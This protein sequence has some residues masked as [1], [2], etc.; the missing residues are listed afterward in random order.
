[1]ENYYKILDTAL[2]IIAPGRRFTI[3][4]IIEEAVADL[5]IKRYGSNWEQE[6]ELFWNCFDTLRR[7][8]IKEA[9]VGDIPY[10]YSMYYMLLNIPKIQMVLIQLMRRKH[11]NRTL[12]VLDIG[13][14]VGTATIALVDLISLLD[15]LCGLYNQDSFFDKITI[16]SIE[17]SADNITVFNENTSCFNDR[18]QG[19]SNTGKFEIITPQQADITSFS[20]EGNYDLVILSNVLNEIPYNSR[21]KLISELEGHLSVNGDMIIIEPASQ[22]PATE[23]N[24]LKKDIVNTTGLKCIAPCGVCENCNEC[25]IY[26]ASDLCKCYLVDYIDKLYEKRE[27]TKFSKYHNNRLKWGYIILS[28]NSSP[29]LS[30]DLSEV[31]S[32]SENIVE[33]NIIGISGNGYWVCDGRMNKALLVGTGDELGHYYFGDFI[34]LEKIRLEKNDSYKIHFQSDSSAYIHYANLSKEKLVFQRV[35][36]ENL[37]YL[38][39]RLW[40]FDEFREGQVEIIQKV[41]QGDDILGL[42][43]TGA[44][45]S[46]CYQLPTMLGNGVS[47]IVSPLKSL[48]KDQIANLRSIGFEFVDFIDSSKSAAEKTITLKRFNSGVIKLL[49]VTPERLQ[50]LEFQNELKRLLKK[51][52]IDYFIIDEAHCASEWGHDFRPS[53]LKLRDIAKHISSASIV[54]VTATASPRVKEDILN[55]FKIEE[56][57]VISSHSLDRPEIS[58]QVVLL[59]INEDKD[60]YL[61]EVLQKDL[62]AVF[63]ED[64]I[65]NIHSGGAGIVFTI[66]AL[67]KGRNTKTYGTEHVLQVVKNSQI[68]AKLYHSRLKDPERD[69]IQDSFKNDRFPLLVSTKGFGMGIDKPNIRYIIHMCYTNSLEA[70]YQE[71]GRAGRDG[72]HAHSIVIAR[73][74]HRQC[75][76]N[77]SNGYEPP[78][79][80]AWVCKYTEENKCDYGMQAWF[81]SDQYPA[82][83]KIRASM[84]KFYRDLLRIHNGK[85]VFEFHAMGEDNSKKYQV[86]LFYFQMKGVIVNYVTERYMNKGKDMIFLVKVN[87]NEFSTM[88][89]EP[90]IEEIV[91]RILGFK[92]QKYNMLESMWEYV[93]NKTKCRRQMLMDYLNDDVSYGDGGCKFCDIDGISKEKSIAVRSSIRMKR[94][95]EEYQILL[96]KDKFN[97][98]KSKFLLQ[99]FYAESRQENAMIRA[100][101]HLEDYPDSPVALY[102]RSIISLKRNK[103]EAYALNQAVRLVNLL[104]ERCEGYTVGLLI[105]DYLDIDEDLAVQILAAI[106]ISNIETV[107]QIMKSINNN[108]FEEIISKAFL[109]SKVENL[110]KLFS[111]RI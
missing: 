31:Y 32:N 43:P 60:K 65:N 3:S 87:P 34:R 85:D 83:D 45:K 66:Y 14:G 63:H 71:A 106:N 13:C 61:T 101:R 26:Q 68:N 11:I 53:Y 22:K 46:V 78:C 90:I 72:E 6:E 29:D 74:R 25:W 47:L 58:F 56:S 77:T 23:L 86:Y 15:N 93:C 2:N 84:R 70:Y 79:V 81:I 36:R 8:F 97:Y 38:L 19:F 73:E 96:G 40:G 42:L 52:P 54:A 44:G 50:V 39:K 110:N 4:K 103:R 28:K 21:K 27:Q 37:R 59:P 62:P 64:S 17:G 49:Y 41:L 94:L 105:N 104:I 24:W 1:M 48:I 111:R 98:E 33:V 95:F 88:N 57:N 76:E 20:I 89:I 82:A 16:S 51:V 100:M 9:Y 109:K 10:F 92:R 67:S 107:N 99:T 18:L 69:A 80:D 75:L 55:I 102:F 30:T 108:Y 91:E 5:L 7:N 35:K 12:K